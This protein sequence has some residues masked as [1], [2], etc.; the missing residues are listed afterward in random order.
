MIEKC[1][2]WSCVSVS[3]ARHNSIKDGHWNII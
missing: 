3:E 2:C 1:S